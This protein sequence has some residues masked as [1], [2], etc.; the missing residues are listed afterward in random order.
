MSQQILPSASLQIDSSD[1]EAILS[2][3]GRIWQ[4][5]R[6]E[7]DESLAEEVVDFDLNSIQAEVGHPLKGDLMN[8][9]Q[10]V[11]EVRTTWWLSRLLMMADGVVEVVLLTCLEILFSPSR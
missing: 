1:D 2:S 11:A 5:S 9:I 7:E 10:E 4:F 3:S 8:S 6:P